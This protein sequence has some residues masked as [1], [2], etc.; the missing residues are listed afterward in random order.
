MDFAKKIRHFIRC[1][2]TNN[3]LVLMD[4]SKKVPIPY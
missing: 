4:E 3:K 2:P 1:C